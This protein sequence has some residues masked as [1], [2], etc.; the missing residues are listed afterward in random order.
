MVDE[1]IAVDA[2]ARINGYVADLK[3]MRGIEREA[4]VADVVLQR[5][6]E[7][8]FVNLI[9][10]CIDLAEHIRASEDLQDAGTSREAVLALA[11]AEILSTETGQKL[12]EAVG[13]RNVLT[14]QYGTLD[15][16]VVYVALHD[17]LHWFEQFQ[18][19]IA[20][21]LRTHM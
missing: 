14:H 12:A 1:E 7:R 16:D 19:E 9:Q 17:D 18:R 5:A 11:E 20:A 4:Y 13:F 2:L 3:E 21:W 15:H 8:T 6:V 10:S